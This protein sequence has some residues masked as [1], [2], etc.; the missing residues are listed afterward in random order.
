MFGFEACLHWSNDENRENK[1][2]IGYKNMRVLATVGCCQTAGNRKSTV[3]LA[4]HIPA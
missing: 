3:L 2:T 1:Y 4:Q